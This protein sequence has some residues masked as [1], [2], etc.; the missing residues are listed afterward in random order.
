MPSAIAENEPNG[1]TA[2]PTPADCLSRRH[3]FVSQRTPPGHLSA[4]R[5]PVRSQSANELRLS[6]AA[7]RPPTRG[8]PAESALTGRSPARTD[9]SRVDEPTNAA[10][11]AAT[12]SGTD[13]RLPLP[14]ISRRP[15]TTARLT[16]RRFLPGPAGSHPGSRQ[17][18]SLSRVEGLARIYSAASSSYSSSTVSERWSRC[19]SSAT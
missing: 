18:V 15:Y 13:F 19:F 6:A 9:A 5:T 12:L 10:A 17:R 2:C 11:P 3:S 7:H 14:S 8:R 1:A 16:R 4:A